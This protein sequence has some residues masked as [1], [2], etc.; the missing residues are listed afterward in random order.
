M[1]YKE[2]NK[3]KIDH[4]QISSIQARINQDLA[5]YFIATADSWVEDS[6]TKYIN[7]ACEAIQESTKGLASGI[8]NFNNY[9]NSISEHFKDKD[10][11]LAGEIEGV[12]F[13]AV[14]SAKQ[15]A[16][17]KKKKAKTSTTYKILP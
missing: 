4:S 1:R 6:S 9:L 12:T 5:H 15:Q 16:A 2:V 7:G 10:T 3:I 17:Q 11:K 8:Y 14:P 13:K